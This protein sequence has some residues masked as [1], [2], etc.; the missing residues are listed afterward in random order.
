MNVISFS[1]G[2][3]STAMLLA[4]IER[5]EPIHSVIWF[6]TERE[7]PE[8][9]CHIGKIQ[10]DTH[11]PFFT[12]RH[13][14]GFNFLEDRYGAPHKSGGWCTAAKRD[15][16]N[17]YMRL[18]VKDHAK[19]EPPI[20]IN[21]CVGFAADETHRDAEYGKK[22]PVRFPLQEYG[23]S[24]ADCLEY[25]YS[26]GYDF[27]GIYNW[28]PS[29]R[30]SCYDCPKQTKADWCAIEQHHPELVCNSLRKPK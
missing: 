20:T 4:M 29:K 2:K 3:D 22:W 15:C 19:L 14:I 8:I 30:V 9:L 7:F 13:W 17:K 18:V 12:L 28:M 21:E 1:G 11:V 23:M 24:E 26:K 10:K 25:C 6:D 5:N 16:C 27:G